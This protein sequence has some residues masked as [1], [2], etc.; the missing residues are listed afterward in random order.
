MAKPRARYQGVTER[1]TTESASPP[2]P[3]AIEGV[4]PKKGARDIKGK[5]QPPGQARLTAPFSIP[6]TTASKSYVRNFFVRPARVCV[7]VFL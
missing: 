3:D 4:A 6:K 1:V 5:R 7:S 2:P